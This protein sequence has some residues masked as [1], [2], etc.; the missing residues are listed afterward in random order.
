MKNK[1][2]NKIK[3]KIENKNFKKTKTNIKPYIYNI[4]D[5]YLLQNNHEKNSNK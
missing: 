4:I 2:K 1:T 3:Q 5:F